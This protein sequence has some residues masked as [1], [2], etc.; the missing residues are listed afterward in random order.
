MLAE[1]HGWYQLSKIQ[2][3]VRGSSWFPVLCLCLQAHLHEAGDCYSP[4]AACQNQHS[5][6]VGITQTSS[7]SFQPVSPAPQ[8]LSG[9][10]LPT[11]AVPPLLLARWRC[12]SADLY[13]L[14]KSDE[15]IP[16]QDYHCYFSAAPWVHLTSDER[17]APQKKECTGPVVVLPFCIPLCFSPHLLIAIK[18]FIFPVRPIFVLF[19]FGQNSLQLQTPAFGQNNV[20]LPYLI[21]VKP[22]EQ[23]CRFSCCCYLCTEQC[24][25]PTALISC[26]YQE[27]LAPSDRPVLSGPNQ[28]LTFPS[29]Q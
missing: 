14:F 18:S 21:P 1:D 16:L 8:L 13:S 17:L 28:D 3:S 22:G 25:Q 23:G 15:L 11:A 27:W 26:D 19:S 12:W 6:S 29:S 5:P 2:A 4:P 20:Q 7:S 24:L 9:K 10:L